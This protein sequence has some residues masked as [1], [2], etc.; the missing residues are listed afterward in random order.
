MHDHQET[1][2]AFAIPDL[3]E[4]SPFADFE[5]YENG[6]STEDRGAPFATLKSMNNQLDSKSEKLF[7][8]PS[9][10]ENATPENYFSS[11]FTFPHPQELDLHL[12]SLISFD[13]GPLENLEDLEPPSASSIA[14]SI[15]SLS[16]QGEEEEDIW[17]ATQIIDP[18]PG[19]AEFKSWERFHN[20]AS[21]EPRTAYLSEGGPSA[22]DAAVVSHLKG[23]RPDL[24][25]E[26][27]GPV[28]QCGPV[29]HVRSPI[30]KHFN[31]D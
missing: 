15:G 30:S 26:L 31:H 12:P 29:L 4:N 3:W 1:G 5:R 9:S 21:K 20:T 18:D 10:S 2:S 16:C 24:P 19:P 7:G 28:L 8:I 17:S 11:S 6:P 14:G 25:I 22:F 27:A 13:Y 23:S